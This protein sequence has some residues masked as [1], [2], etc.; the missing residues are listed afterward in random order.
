MSS[1]I[2]FDAQLARRMANAEI[3]IAELKE[4][5]S[6]AREAIKRVNALT[7]SNPDRE[8]AEFIY[9]IT[10]PALIKTKG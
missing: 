5:L 8:E 10:A 6:I 7:N 2:G 1:E 3:E 9:S 4:K